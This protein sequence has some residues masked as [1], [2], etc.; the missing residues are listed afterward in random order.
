[1]VLKTASPASQYAV[2][3]EQESD[4]TWLAQ[5]FGWSECRTQTLNCEDAIEQLQR[6][7]NERLSKAEILYY[8]APVS[9]AEHPWMKD[10]GIYENDPLFEEVLEDIREYRRELDASR[11][12]MS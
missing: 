3:V 5:V 11:F 7:L 4:G 9:P 6:V 8:N 10:A 1:M 12:E 2:V